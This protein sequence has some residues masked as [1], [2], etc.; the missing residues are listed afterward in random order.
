LASGKISI[1]NLIGQ[2]INYVS[3]SEVYPGDRR[4]WP[5]LRR[6]KRFSQKR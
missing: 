2:S 5:F 4:V 1:R 3:A 6:G